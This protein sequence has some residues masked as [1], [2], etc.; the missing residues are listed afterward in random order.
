MGSPIVSKLAGLSD[1]H[2]WRL[3]ILGQNGGGQKA[4][5]SLHLNIRHLDMCWKLDSQQVILV[6]QVYD[7]S[8]GTL[9]ADSP[10][11]QIDTFN[12]PTRRFPTYSPS[13]KND[14]S[15][16]VLR[17]LLA[18]CSWSVKWLALAQ[19]KLVSLG[20]SAASCSCCKGHSIRPD[21]CAHKQAKQRTLV[22]ACRS[23]R[24]R[25]TCS[26]NSFDTFDIL[27][28]KQCDSK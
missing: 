19:G 2:R 24:L 12:S 7:S 17:E 28:F 3:A 5:C 8:L 22:S 21:K 6:D 4:R 1:R 27:A 10:V 11:H 20:M 15:L 16:L 25:D 18:V 9:P 23:P 26:R 13:R 14:S